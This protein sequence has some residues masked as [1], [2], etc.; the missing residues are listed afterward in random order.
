M[1][2][3]RRPTVGRR[4]AVPTG[5]PR[6]ELARPVADRLLDALV[7]R[8]A[9]V[10]A[11]Q[12][13]EDQPEEP[14]KRMVLRRAAVRESGA[15]PG[16][17]RLL[18]VDEI[19]RWIRDS[20]VLL[21]LARGESVHIPYADLTAAEH[22]ADQLAS[23][24]LADAARGTAVVLLPLTAD[25]R[26]LGNVLLFGGPDRPPYHER[27]IAF[28][29]EL[30][31][32]GA[33]LMDGALAA[34]LH[35]AAELRVPPPVPGV[36]L[37]YRYLPRAGHQVGGD[38][39]DLIPLPGG[40]TA[41][42]IGDVQGHGP[43][44]AVLM[45]QCRTM[46]R[47][48][49]ALDPE[50]A[51]LLTRMD[52]LLRQDHS[53]VLVTCSYLV[54]HPGIEECR[55]ATAG[56]VPLVA[57]HPSGRPEVIRAPAGAPL[58][59]G[60][61]E[62][63]TAEFALPDRGLLVL[64]TDGLIDGPADIDAGIHTVAELAGGATD[65][66]TACDRLVARLAPFRDDVT[67]LMARLT[68]RPAERSAHAEAG[69]EP[70]AAHA[71]PAVAHDPAWTNLRADT[72]T[73]FGRAN[74]LAELRTMLLNSRLVTVTGPA[75]VGKSRLVRQ[76]AGAL[77][78]DFPDGLR[79]VDLSGERDP[80][81]IPWAVGAAVG[82]LLDLESSRQ[83]LVL[84]GCEFLAEACADF[85]RSLLRATPTVRI[86]V[87]GRRPLGVTGEH[88]MR[89]RP[90]APADAA[91]MLTA[92]RGGSGPA[93]AEEV[94]ALDGLP[95]AIELAVE[96]GGMWSAIAR[97]HELCEPLERLLW[98]RLSIF[99]GPFELTAAEHVCTDQ[100]IPAADVL[101]LLDGLVK[102][103]I[104]LRDQGATT[105]RLL[106]VHRAYGRQQLERLAERSTLA[107]RHREWH[108]R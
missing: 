27:D 103:S 37:A 16:M 96:G 67:L 13:V 3:I 94:A 18:P 34:E 55:I 68:A 69:P 79:L 86:L 49:A 1:A 101:S 72:T 70:V 58:G 82:S 89:L 42:V 88:I 28:L 12:L 22:L 66:E 90:L 104:V 2:G 105:Y 98:A 93:S 24:G 63:R 56:H 7:P 65:L 74:E 30:A 43:R 39:F 36:D 62:F 76:A 77:R 48:L 52:A 44:A 19:V 4:R 78:R 17:T 108:Q 46:V 10:A 102:K 50:P 20:P 6:P 53:D 35:Y 47:A 100:M 5:T 33:E 60:G 87:T 97:S 26:L 99:E 80:G 71:E 91:A 57:V 23:P 45:A 59:V 81:R 51:E 106:G 32:W 92:L 8:F 38:W 15:L 64:F 29:E 14:D 31:R 95:L 84:D 85:A 107:R 9:D 40:R 61:V 75:G 83:I 73:F 54:Y 21:A 11:V 25:G 41:F